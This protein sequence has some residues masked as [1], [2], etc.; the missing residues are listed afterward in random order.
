MDAHVRGI[1]VRYLQLAA[2]LKAHARGV[3][4]RNQGQLLER[5][6]GRQEHGHFHHRHNVGQL[7]GLA[8]VKFGGQHERFAEHVLPQ[9]AERLGGH[10]ALVAPAPERHF[11]VEHVVL[12]VALLHLAQRDVGEILGQETHLALVA[13]HGALGI[14]P[15]GLGAGELFELR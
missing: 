9:E 5:P 7:E 14:V 15:D 13:G 2:F 3:V 4:Q 8:R 12:D 6:A 1:N 10:A 11:D